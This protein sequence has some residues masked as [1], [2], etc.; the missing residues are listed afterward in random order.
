MI[1][2][3]QTPVETPVEELVTVTRPLNQ[4]LIAVDLSKILLEL[5]PNETLSFRKLPDVGQRD[6]GI[7]IEAEVL[8]NG[9]SY[10]YAEVIP[11]SKLELYKFDILADTIQTVL[12]KVRKAA[13]EDAQ[14]R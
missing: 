6:I 2:A 12:G 8:A 3:K 4:P 11:S 7:Y 13:A 10:T 14:A 9:H 1:S 5:R